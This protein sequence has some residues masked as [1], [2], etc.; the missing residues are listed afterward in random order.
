MSGHGQSPGD[1]PESLEAMLMSRRVPGQ[2]PNQRV[3]Q[4]RLGECASPFPASR[5]ARRVL[6]PTQ[7]E[8]EGGSPFR[9]PTPAAP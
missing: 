9:R 4:H 3:A 7:G 2:P 8:G 5:T 1:P 6:P